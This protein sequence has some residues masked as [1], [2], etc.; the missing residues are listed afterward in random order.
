M[1]F[2]RWGY[3]IDGPY[4]SSDSLKPRAGVYIIWCKK[5][6]SLTVIDVGES[7]NV[8]ERVNNHERFDCWIRHCSG[9]TYY[10]ATYTPNL[11]QAERIQ[12]EQKIRRLTNL[13]CGSS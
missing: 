3:K 4:A 6:D 12:I 2:E 8:K 10:S 1:G 9:T 7:A 5:G 13:P 11:Q